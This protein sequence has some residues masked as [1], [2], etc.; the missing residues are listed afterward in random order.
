MPCRAGPALSRPPLLLQVY[1]E[2]RTEGECLSNIREFL[3]GCGASLRLEVSRGGGERGAREGRCLVRS[4][5]VDG[6]R[7]EGVFLCPVG[8]AVLPTLCARGRPVAGG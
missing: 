1:P 7:V 3:R 8:D 6:G 5:G 4:P 2:P